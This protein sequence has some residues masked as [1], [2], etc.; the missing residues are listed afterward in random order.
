METYKNIVYSI[1]DGLILRDKIPN[2]KD[3]LIAV[4]KSKASKPKRV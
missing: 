4:K 2:A 3:T 1:W